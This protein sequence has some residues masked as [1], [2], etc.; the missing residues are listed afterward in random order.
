MLKYVGKNPA[1][2]VKYGVLLTFIEKDN[3]ILMTSLYFPSSRSMFWQLRMFSSVG[4]S[5][6][7]SGKIDV[8]QCFIMSWWHS[9]WFSAPYVP[10][11][12]SLSVM[13][14]WLKQM[15]GPTPCW[16]GLW[17]CVQSQ[18]EAFG[19]L[20]IVQGTSPY[21]HPSSGQGSGPCEGLPWLCPGNA[22]TGGQPWPCQGIPLSGSPAFC[23]ETS[24]SPVDDWGTCPA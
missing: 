15:I 13:G 20:Q 11:M 1:Q 4:F 16:Q 24:P 6:L 10:K 12:T 14:L 22:L 2:V 19:A 17:A 8:W 18:Y 3:L 5:V 21:E 23:Q 7:I 9:H